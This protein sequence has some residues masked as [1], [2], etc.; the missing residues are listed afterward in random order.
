[1]LLSFHIFWIHF[2]SLKIASPVFSQ[3][4]LLVRAVFLTPALFI[5]SKLWSLFCTEKCQGNWIY[6][7]RVCLCVCL[8]KWVEMVCYPHC[9]FCNVHAGQAQFLC[10]GHFQVNAL[11]FPYHLGVLAFLP[12]YSLHQYSLGK[13][14]C[15]CYYFKICYLKFFVLFCFILQCYFFPNAKILA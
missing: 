4:F 15:C 2:N 7:C 11:Y 13:N 3:Y 9:V 1:M 6:L 12:T 14:D 10:S 8:W 5:V